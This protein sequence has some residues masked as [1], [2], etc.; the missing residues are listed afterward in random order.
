MHFL[1]RVAKF[2]LI[3]AFLGSGAYFAHFNREHV[4]L[5]LPPWIEHVTLPAYLVYGGSFLVGTLVTSLFFGI[6]NLRKTFE[7]RRLQ[8]RVRELEPAPLTSAAGSPLSAAPL[9][10]EPLP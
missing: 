2:W 1:G 7:I 8:R 6:D 5:Q 9:T 3:L 4:G 10:Q